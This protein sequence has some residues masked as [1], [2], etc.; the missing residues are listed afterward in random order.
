VG[1][2]E[3]KEKRETTAAF[4][5]TSLILENWMCTE[6]LNFSRGAFP[7]AVLQFSWLQ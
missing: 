4:Q 1:L 2:G 5:V 7:D 3:G 6:I